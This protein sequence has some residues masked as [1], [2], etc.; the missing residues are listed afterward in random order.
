MTWLPLLGI[1]AVPL[2]AYRI[3]RFFVWDSLIG[4][5]PDTKTKMALRVDLW[6]YDAEGRDRTWF[7]GKV[8]DLL[9]CPWCLGFWIS[10]A[11]YLAWIV[12]FGLW[13]DLPLLAHGLLAWAVS[14]VQGFLD[15]KTE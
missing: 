1:L 4:M 8:G 15:S 3:T 11:C 6:A 5:N 12:P 7:R 9:G 10:M 14:G 2:A 13:H